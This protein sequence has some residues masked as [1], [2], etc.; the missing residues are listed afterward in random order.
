MRSEFKSRKNVRVIGIVLKVVLFFALAG[1]L[2][3]QLYKQDWTTMQSIRLK[4]PIYLIL[5]LLLVIANQGCEWMKWK[6]VAKTLTRNPKILRDAFFGGIGAGFLTPNGW[7]NFLGRMVFF[8]KR[9]RLYILLSAFMSNVSQVLPTVFFGAIACLYSSRMD[10]QLGIFFL[11]VGACIL[12]LFFFGEFLIPRKQ[13]RSKRWIRR[14]HFMKHRLVHLRLP[15]F[16]WSL[17]RFCIFSLQ[18][19]LLFMAFGYG[20]F[21]FLLNQVWLIF[22]LT[23]FV[24]SLWSGKLLIRETA[25]VYVFTGTIVTVPD[26]IVVSLLIWLFNIILPAVISTYVWLPLSKR[27]VHVVD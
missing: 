1:V 4:H 16:L 8:R 19:V 23:S 3:W 27:E 13:P 6:R 25:A 11:M 10:Q 21:F 15:L 7:G 5:S 22:L 14:L 26:V 20:D 17:L 9:E 12:L 18:Y 24:P 2:T